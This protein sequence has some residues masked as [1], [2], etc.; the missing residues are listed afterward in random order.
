MG[1]LQ[2]NQPDT[3]YFTYQN[4]GDSPL[5]I[6]RA[7]AS[8]GCTDPIWEKRPLKPGKE[9][10][11]QVIYNAESPGM[12]NKTIT[13]YGNTKEKIHILTIRGRVEE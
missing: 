1:L 7:V 10:S 3:V 2:Y 11:L 8:C 13:V 6:Y 4:K 9:G 5:V 12:F